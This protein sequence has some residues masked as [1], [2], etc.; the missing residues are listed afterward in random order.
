[1]LL[2]RPKQKISTTASEEVKFPASSI[3]GLATVATSGSY[4]DLID[5]PEAPGV[6][7][8]VQTT[9]ISTTA[10][11]SQKAV[12]DELNAI[13][14]HSYIELTNEDLNTIMQVGWYRAAG[15]NDCTNKPTVIS[16]NSFI[17]IVDSSNDTII[18]Q[19]LYYGTSMVSY[20]SRYTANAGTSWTDWSKQTTIN[21]YL[22][23]FIGRKTFGNGINL[24]ES[25]RVKGVDG[26]AGQILTASGGTLAP[27]WVDMPTFPTNV[28]EYVPQSLTEEEK[29]QARTNISAGT[30]NFSGNYN[31]LSNKPTIPTDYVPNTRKVNNKA[32]SSDITLGASDVGALPTSGGTITGNLTV[33]GNLTVNGT[34]TTVDS[35]TL[36]VKDKLI[37]VA[38][39]NTA[40]L[41]TPAGLVAPKYDGTNS[42][43]LVFDS[44]G[45]AYVGDVT[46][47]DGNI[48]VANSGL[49][50]LATRTGLVGGNLVQYDSSAQTLKDSG[51]KI[52]DLALKTDIPTNYV[53]TDTTQTIS[54]AK[55]FVSDIYISQTSGQ[56]A[57]ITW[58]SASDNTNRGIFR[59]YDD[60]TTESF[61]A[62]SG[63]FLFRPLNN[64]NT[65]SIK[66][67]PAVGAL[68]PEQNSG[69]DLG[70][71]AQRW[72]AVYAGNTGVRSTG[73]IICDSK[74][75]S[76]SAVES[77]KEVPDFNAILKDDL[78]TTAPTK[79]RGAQYLA[80][81]KNGAYL[82]GLRIYHDTNGTIQSQ[83]LC[84][85]QNTDKQKNVALVA[86]KD[87][88]GAAGD[89]R[90]VPNGDAVIDLGVS[91]L[92]WRNVRAVT[93]YSDVYG[94]DLC[95]TGSLRLKDPSIIRGTNQ[96]ENGGEK[97]Y[98]RAININDKNNVK[99]VAV[100]WGY[101]CA[102]DA[103]G[104]T[105]T[106][107]SEINLLAYQPNTTDAS[108][109]TKLALGKRFDG[110]AYLTWD[111][112]DVAVKSDIKAQVAYGTC[113][114]AAA[115]AAKVVTV[116]DTTWALTPGTIVGV[117]FT[118]TN[119]ASNVTINVNGTGAKNIWYNNAKQTGNSNLY[120]GYANR[121]I[122]YMYDGTYWCWL[123]AGAENDTISSAMSWTGGS[124]KDKTAACHNYS[125]LAK[126]YTQVIMISSNTAKSALTLNINGK[127]AKPI[128]INGAASSATN[129]TLPAGSYFVYYDGTNYYFRTDGKFTVGSG[130]AMTT[131][132]TS[133]TYT[134]PKANGT[135]MV[136]SL[137][138]TV[139]TI[140][141]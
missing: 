84:R 125:L 140:S 109:F 36:Q 89:W 13:A 30:S 87:S 9:G 48:D 110:S 12:T 141:L 26:S 96:A 27:K 60:G 3:D 105:T 83:L 90:F 91:D 128:Y 97:K 102:K 131:G 123:N 61:V 119:T 106:H 15:N 46:L 28:V 19:T 54:G 86:T 127:G 50:P 113:A 137:S 7:D 33:G 22:Q 114:T 122:Y 55:T 98:Y 116:S 39:G 51:K 111:S 52:S 71:T 78:Y 136:G 99:G 135:M 35:T 66:V 17:L 65:K 21:D 25:L 124:T 1:M 117:K 40:T 18:R 138:G 132:G 11:M 130:L 129:Y 76:Y 64:A 103:N 47:K 92:R 121:L 41:T 101:L 37:E 62:Q 115:T 120:A 24:N 43:A 68:Y 73:N 80:R 53:T 56:N 94:S 6:P 45:T 100:E 133:Y 69:A 23:T 112:K 81:D 139:L 16:T 82:G 44:T 57:G 85:S 34:T 77:N 108:K 134:L 4:N 79:T 74:V 75:I 14:K 38:H 42:G 32:L 95:S 104:N 58:Q 29:S 8:I 20:Y 107:T 72:N 59:H 49:Q 88:T 70:K 5:K 10:V 126:S 2:Y 93:T 31:D 67:D 63:G 118:N